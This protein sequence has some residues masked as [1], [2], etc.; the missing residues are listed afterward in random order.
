M[1]TRRRANRAIEAPSLL[2]VAGVLLP[3]ATAFLSGCG[4]EWHEFHG[5]SRRDR[6]NARE[7]RGSQRADGAG[8][9]R[10]A[11]QRQP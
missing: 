7:L 5:A 9:R 4:S 3:V 11:E 8:L 10:Q 6:Y 2:T 1:L